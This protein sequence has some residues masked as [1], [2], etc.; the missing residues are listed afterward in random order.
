M[1]A[2]QQYAVREVALATFYDIKTGKAR[3]QLQNLKTSGLENSAETVYARGG[4]GN[5]K[6][7]GFSSNRETKVKLQDALITNEVLAMLTSS[8]VA[9]ASANIYQRDELVVHTNAASLKFT[10]AATGSLI[11]VYKLNA[12]GT[13]GTELTYTALTVSSGKYAI[14]GKTLS[15]FA[16]EIADGAKVVA[17]YKTETGQDASSI[18]VSSD[19]FAG[20]FKIVLDCLVRDAYTK[21]DYAAQIVINN[22]K[23]LDNF[24]FSM[25]STGD[26]TMLDIELD[27][28]K[29]ISGNDM[30]TITVYD[31]SQLS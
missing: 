9:V 17:Y 2:P 19:K 15:F 23:L 5:A 10:P 21:Q 11:S 7:V 20:S 8:N 24:K 12:D 18:T 30:W 16:S 28:L 6:I 14:S 22:A 25:A 26:P 27:V 1:A 31:E 3:V 29:P 4:R 13:H